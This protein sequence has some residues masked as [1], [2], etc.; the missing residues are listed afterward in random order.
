MGS[1]T[2]RLSFSACH[3]SADL[4]VLPE[5]IGLPAARCWKAG[6][7]RVSPRGAATGGHFTYSS[8]GIEFAAAESLPASLVAA[9]ARLKPHKDFLLQLANKGVQFRF[10][11]GWFSDFN[12]GERLEWSLLR[13]IAD[14][15]IS[16]DFDVYGPDAP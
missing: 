15:Q 13:D 2:H 12:S 9:V 7:L 10:F 11:I 1:Y 3:D 5:V 4:S 16:L 8:C 6:D 14:L